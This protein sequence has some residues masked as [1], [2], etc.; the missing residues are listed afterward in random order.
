M[1]RWTQYDWTANPAERK[2]REETTWFIE[3]V[4]SCPFGIN[5]H[6]PL[7]PAGQRQRLGRCTAQARQWENGTTSVLRPGHDVRDRLGTSGSAKI[8]VC[9]LLLPRLDPFTKMRTAIGS[10]SS[11]TETSVRQ[12]RGA[13]RN[14]IRFTSVLVAS[15]S[16]S[17]RTVKDH[18]CGSARGQNPIWRH[19]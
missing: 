9:S 18:A 15:L 4:S 12:S 13:S 14:R 7:C 2:Y 17:K 3:V 19:A 10:D 16:A 6:A 11:V 5:S 8:D 1:E